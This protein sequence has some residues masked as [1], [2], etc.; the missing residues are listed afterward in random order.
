MQPTSS[1]ESKY[2]ENVETTSDTHIW[3]F[4]QAP[5]YAFAFNPAKVKILCIFK[6]HNP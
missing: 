6:S 2:E 1:M 5:P 4:E 3:R